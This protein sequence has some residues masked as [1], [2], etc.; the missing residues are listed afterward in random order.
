MCTNMLKWYDYVACLLFADLIVSGIFF[1]YWINLGVGILGY[2]LYE[3]YRKAVTT[4]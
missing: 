2:D 1:G 4:K 3:S